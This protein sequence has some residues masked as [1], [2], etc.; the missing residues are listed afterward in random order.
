MV[1]STTR[2]LNNSTG[3]LTFRR[4]WQW[5]C[6]FLVL[7]SLA[8]VGQN[9][10]LNA[11]CSITPDPGTIGNTIGTP[12]VIS[13]NLGVSSS[14]TI[15]EAQLN[16]KGISAGTSGPPPICHLYVEDP[17]APGT[18]IDLSVPANAISFAC[19]GSGDYM[20]GDIIAVYSDEDGAIGNAAGPLYVQIDL[21][22]TDIPS[23]TNS[24]NGPDCSETV[25]LLSQL[26]YIYTT[27]VPSTGVSALQDCRSAM[28]WRTPDFADNC[29]VDSVAICFRANSSPGPATIPAAITYGPNTTPVPGSF[30]ITP[31][32]YFY[33]H[34]DACSATT[35]VTYKVFDASGNVDSC[36]IDVVVEDNQDPI[37]DN[38]VASLMDSL[39]ADATISGFEDYDPTPG[40]DGKQVRV[41]LDCNSEYYSSDSAYL[42]TWMPTASDNCDTTV[43][44]VQNHSTAN[45]EACITRL[46]IDN[47]Y[48]RFAHFFTAADNCAPPNILDHDVLMNDMDGDDERFRLVVLTADN[49]S[50][51][52]DP[53]STG[54]RAPVPV[55]ET[56]LS[57]DD[58]LK[59]VGTDTVKF[60]VGPGAT[61]CDFT[62][63]TDT[64][65]ILAIDCQA[66]DYDWT[67]IGSVDQFGNPTGLAGSTCSGGPAMACMDIANEVAVWP[68]G[69][70]DIQYTAADACGLTTTFDFVLQI[71]DTI[72]PEIVDCPPAS[73]M[74][75]TICVSA[76]T[77]LC[78]TTVGWIVPT[79]QDCSG[80][81]TFTGTAADPQGNPITVFSGAFPAVGCSEDFN[82]TG[83]FVP[84]NWY[85]NNNGGSGGASF[86][87]A[88]ASNLDIVSNV[89]FFAPDMEVN[90]NT[91][92][93][94]GVIEFSYSRP[95]LSLF[96][97]TTLGYYTD[98]LGFVSLSGGSLVTYLNGTV[99]VPVK[100]GERFAFIMTSSFFAPG[101]ATISN[102]SFQCKEGAY[103]IFPVGTSCV[104]Y[105]AVDALGNADTCKFFV[106][107]IDD[108]PPTFQN[109][110]A[111]QMLFMDEIDCANPLVPDYTN[112]AQVQ[113][114][115]SV[116]SI[117]QAPP[118]GSSLMTAVGGII[119]HDS[120]FQI[121]ITA[122]SA[123]TFSRDTFK[124]TIKDNIA[125][126]LV[127]PGDTTIYADA[128]CEASLVG[129]LPAPVYM[130][131]C[132]VT[133][134]ASTA[135]SR[136]DG[137]A[138][139]DPFGLGT[140]TVTYTYTDDGGNIA[141]CDFD[142]I[143]LDTTPPV[144]G[145]L[146]DI[147]ASADP[148]SCATNVSFSVTA[149]DNCTLPGDIVIVTSDAS[150]D[151][152]GV[153][154]HN[155]LVTATD[156]SGNATQDS[157]YITVKDLEPPVVTCPAAVNL[158]SICD[159]LPV[160][161]ISASAVDNC[162]VGMFW[163]E[164]ATTLTL[165]DVRAAGSLYG[166]IDMD[167]D[168]MVSDGD[169]FTVRI[170]A[171]DDD[172]GLKDT[173]YT[174]V[175]LFD[176]Q[177][178]VPDIL[179]TLP[180]L[181]SS[182]CELDVPAP[183]AHDC[184]SLVYGF[185]TQGTLIQA[186]PPIYRFVTADPDQILWTY[187]DNQG[188]NT[189]QVQQ[190][191]VLDDTTPPSVEAPAD[192]SVATDTDMCSATGISGLSMSE[193]TLPAILTAG[194]Y[195]D[196][197]G[198]DSVHYELFGATTVARK[199]GTNAGLETFNHGM[200]WVVYF[201]K[202]VK[203]NESSDTTKVTVKD[204][205]AP[206]IM[207][208]PAD[209][210]VNCDA[211]PAP[212]SPTV[213]DNCSP[214]ADITLTMMAD[215]VPGLCPHEMVITRK[216]TATDTCANSSMMTQVL[217]VQDTTPPVFPANAP[218]MVMVN[219]D[220]GVCSAVV[221]LMI[222][223]VT[224]NC[225]SA[226]NIMI[227]NSE[228]GNGFDASDTYNVGT[229]IVT[230]TATDQCGN[231]ATHQVSVVVKDNEEP[232][233]VCI[234][235]GLPINSM[236]M[237]SIDSSDVVLPNFS[238]N[239]AHPSQIT[240]A[241][242]QSKFT[243]DDLMRPQPIAVTVTAT[244]TAG[245]VATCISMV[246]LQETFAPTAN[247]KATYTA[248]L[249]KD[250]EVTVAG[251]ELDNGS[252]DNCPGSLSFLINGLPSQ[253]YDCSHVGLSPFNVTMTVTD[254][255]GNSST[256]ITSLTIA[257]TVPPMVMCQ[258]YTAP[259]GANGTVTILPS[260]V[261]NGS[262]DSCGIASMSVSP[263]LFDCDDLGPNT[264]TLT[265]TDMNG[266]SAS[267][268][269]TVTVVDQMGPD[270]D[271]QDVEVF[272]GTDGTLKIAASMFNDGTT[273]N[274]THP[275]SITFKVN[276][277]DTLMLDC[278]DFGT[279]PITIVACD[280]IGN[281]STCVANLTV[282]PNDTVKFT[283]GTISGASGTTIEIPVTVN[284]FFKVNSFQF[285]VS[286]V[287]PTVAVLQDIVAYDLNAPLI[288]Q[289]GPGNIRTLSWNAPVSGPPPVN[290]LDLNDGDTAF[291]IIVDLIGA[292]S[293][294][295][296][297]ILDGSV[298]SEQVT[299]GCG[300]VVV[301]DIQLCPG[302]VTV[303][304]NT[305]SIIDG[306]IRR[307]GANVA[308]TIVCL[309]G[310]VT[311]NDTT[312]ASGYY[313]FVVPNGS[314][315]TITP[316][317]DV[318]VRNGVLAN[319]AA[320]IRNDVVSFIRTI[321]GPYR[322]LA[323]DVDDSNG[324]LFPEPAV[325]DADI[326]QDL[327]ALIIPDFKMWGLDSWIFV[328]SSFTFMN[329]DFPWLDNPVPSSVSLANVQSNTTTDFEAIKVG[330]VTADANPL[331][332]NGNDPVGRDGA[333]L[334]LNADNHSVV[335]GETYTIDVRARDFIAM[336]AFQMTL[337]FEQGSLVFE[338][339]IEKQ[340]T[341]MTFGTSQLSDGNLAIVWSAGTNLT[342]S[343]HDVL[344]SLKFR[345][346]KDA[347]KLSDLISLSG[348][349][350]PKA[351]FDSELDAMGIELEFEATT[352]TG[353]LNASKFALYQN[354]PNPF[355]AMTVVSFHL[356]QAGTAKLSIHDVSGKLVYFYE[357]DFVQG[358]NE[359]SIERRDLPNAGV[360]YYQLEADDNTAVRKMILID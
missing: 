99:Q 74:N 150:G 173:C 250:G 280:S 56:G 65:K 267:E 126:S 67:I 44:I 2:S 322:L 264:V 18:Y 29:E 212:A 185:T 59:Y 84:V 232:D 222:T 108:Q 316:K 289:P 177:A 287:D 350:T 134:P 156:E 311:A 180:N 307:E 75:D 33:G 214:T 305:T 271:C 66:I 107:V 115:C 251:S 48:E 201:I 216:W 324:S 292:S 60:F 82:F 335:S 231:S 270:I 158:M 281:T 172:Q 331:A 164:P 117:T 211:V 132:G 141:M 205:Q 179:P 317:K 293:T 193:V 140:T 326:I 144:L 291:V 341:N 353:N 109:P 4:R 37:W 104:Q 168:G 97:G 14:V 266:N 245:N 102:F 207:G 196:T 182:C 299:Q 6:S 199:D 190:I 88:P 112:L 26:D 242:S 138:T 247:C 296:D 15:N 295:S 148:A 312:D 204:M 21:V 143:V 127:C 23:I 235:I 298:L 228:N 5:L 8:F 166:Y 282:H 20:S 210:L 51:Y 160:P 332:F 261:N 274:C 357:G 72:P 354:Q 275:D 73:A 93:F 123:D 218:T 79:M 352:S 184:D 52:L 286:V 100:A 237:A 339:S 315:V 269:C 304:A 80:P 31:S 258:N 276:G 125:P 142:V 159:T 76:N 71:C 336:R 319:D 223:G 154:T 351:A 239:C 337:E 225:S 227:T 58:A 268:T 40:G 262:W 320:E 62:I 236:G 92:L 343:D 145:A 103:A 50:P 263:N 202:D 283:A 272:V 39:S 165:E 220:P 152:F 96:S 55:M 85:I 98:A 16:S 338:E 183:T 356:P 95:I 306:H 153:G 101:D 163:Q 345:A 46:G 333:T 70:H 116:D 309:T 1:T 90:Y 35:R 43:T 359:L 119:A 81:G 137:N 285:T 321:P 94:D 157:F 68:I 135:T 347:D 174:K 89:G 191:V 230:F 342:L 349:M 113:D 254:G 151:L 186:N 130:D 330:D 11:Q 121:V 9:N 217:T 181:F 175:T 346:I 38:P 87:G 106:K 194:Q 257:D 45:S 49:T 124:V 24:G 348:A 323:S 329:N 327:L 219:N 41:V 133:T 288:V 47:I 301:T 53:D 169:M 146:P 206:D 30:I 203:G 240:F 13:Y 171:M 246:T 63:T 300:V 110:I 318:F 308:G 139:N 61:D 260:D 213:S 149:T 224:D 243:C 325:N 128:N 229:T 28:I 200:T 161:M 178:P 91:I 54:V 310:D 78:E 129:G 155:I 256:C 360:L 313:S 248:Y 131:S 187:I 334:H 10:E 42:A 69:T 297:V 136:S 358:Y 344:F 278:E 249:D 253:M 19:D 234:N 7:F 226:G 170:I 188:Q 259:L 118:A 64:L 120:M 284:D 215:T 3:N 244:D 25:T 273:D 57:T 162:N 17:G 34:P 277:L 265:V 147:T 32:T 77:G 221:N 86:S 189:Q 238:D 255:A 290:W 328:P 198:V 208:V 192:V 167:S 197:C 114:N 12:L 111:D 279:N 36:W 22:D 195:G 294:M 314:N 83:N 355:K 302:K 27:P 209:T 105:I 252:T 233:I 340:L 122:H 303:D 176:G 241:L